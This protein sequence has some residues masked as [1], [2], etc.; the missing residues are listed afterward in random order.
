MHRLATQRCVRAFWIATPLTLGME[1]LP[2]H[3]RPITH[4]SLTRLGFSAHDEWLRMLGRPVTEAAETARVE[5][6]GPKE[7]ELTIRDPS[8]AT[9]GTATVELGRDGTGIVW[10]LEVKP[11]Y[12]RRSYGRALLLQSTK[13]LGSAGAE[14]LI[15][16]VDHDDPYTRDRRPAI[17][18]YQNVG[19]RTVD[20]LWSYELT[21]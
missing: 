8:D 13:L 11:A 7:W 3:H 5:P 10:W 15:L 14:R 12:R 16:Y 6:R 19:F 4:A 1:A 21:R 2:A 17:G 20:H 9:V 18:L